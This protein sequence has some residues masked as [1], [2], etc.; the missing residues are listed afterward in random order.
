[1]SRP[2]PLW[3]RLPLAV[4]LLALGLLVGALSALVHGL[5]L[6]LVLV[7]MATGATAYALPGGWSTRLPFGLGWLAAVY[8]ASRPRPAGGYLVASDA[9][10]YTLL[11]LGVL[12]LLFCTTTLRP[13]AIP[14]RASSERS[15][16]ACSGE[17]KYGKL[18]SPLVVLR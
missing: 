12:L 17:M 10:G 11:V 9:R 13:R 14:L 6:G 5:L 18:M 8:Y 7:V 15:R 16:I 1:M 2:V 3:L 4:L